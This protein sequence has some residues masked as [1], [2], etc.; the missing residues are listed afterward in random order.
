MMIYFSPQ[1]SDAP[2]IPARLCEAIGRY[3]DR[4]N[5]AFVIWGAIMP[6]RHKVVGCCCCCCFASV[7]LA[8]HECTGMDRP[9]HGSRHHSMATIVPHSRRDELIW[10]III[11]FVYF[12]EFG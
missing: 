10:V 11:M 5:I 12:L 2:S 9:Y 8:K 6:H 3:F 1:L 4:C 7:K